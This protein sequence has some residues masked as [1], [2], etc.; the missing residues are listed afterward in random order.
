MHQQY[1]DLFTD[2]A[3]HEV[4]CKLAK[5][6]R[7]KIAE[8]YPGVLKFDGLT[9]NEFA[10]KNRISPEEKEKIILRTKKFRFISAFKN[11]PLKEGV[12]LPA[13]QVNGDISLKAEVV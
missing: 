11:E 5:D 2:L 6:L 13:S 1:P 3:D 12:R 9:K 7:V 8:Q 4:K 10:A